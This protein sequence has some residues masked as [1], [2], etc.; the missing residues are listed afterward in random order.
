MFIQ[1][2]VIKN[3]DFFDMKLK[4]YAVKLLILYNCNFCPKVINL[5]THDFDLN[6]PT[7]LYLF[8]V[9]SSF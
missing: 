7:I 2:F 3:I 6:L 8:V 4:L 5:Q 1:L 9:K